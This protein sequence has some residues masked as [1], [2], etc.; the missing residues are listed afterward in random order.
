L[1]VGEAAPL[2]VARDVEP[3]PRIFVPP[4]GAPVRTAPFRRSRPAVRSRA[5]LLPRVPQPSA[6]EPF[7]HRI[8]MVRLQLLQRGQQ[9]FLLVGAESGGLSFQDDRPVRVTGRHVRPRIPQFANM[10]TALTAIVINQC[11][12]GVSR[13]GS[14]RFNFSMSV[15]RFRLSS[16]AA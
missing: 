8:G 16:L 5:L 13:P 15:V 12:F 10:V 3:L 7:H 14:S 9:F 4:A 11:G 6:R 2:L 1:F